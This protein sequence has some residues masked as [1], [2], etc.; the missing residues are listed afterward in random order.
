[1]ADCLICGKPLGFWHWHH[2]ACESALASAKSDIETI[3]VGF[4]VNLNDNTA[5]SPVSLQESVSRRA[6]QFGFTEDAV[7]Q[8]VLAGLTRA[9]KTAFADRDVSDKELEKIATIFA[10][11]NIDPHTIAGTAAYAILA[12]AMT[13]R[14]LRRGVLPK[15]LR[16]G[17]DSSLVLK[18]GEQIIWSFDNSARL[19][20]KTS[21]HFEGSS[22][23][24]SIRIVK[25]ISYRVGV[26]KGR[27]VETTSLANCGAGSLLVTNKRVQFLSPAGNKSIDISAIDVVER[28]SDGIGITPKHGKAQ[29]FTGVEPLFAADLILSAAG[30]TERA[31]DKHVTA[32]PVVA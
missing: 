18:E 12:Q 13:L 4:T 30:F 16:S 14:N 3:F 27:R 24:V 9:A 31:P 28:Y 1:M 11:F 22:Q 26:M 32:H 19:E 17:A 2:A 5:P 29:I 15:R 25:G 23:G 21:A 6:Q 10:T 8:V 20:M 7:S